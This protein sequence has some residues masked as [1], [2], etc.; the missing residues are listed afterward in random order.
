MFIMAFGVGAAILAVWADI[1]FEKVRPANLYAAMI[2]VGVAMLLAKFLV[3]LGLHL[4]GSLTTALTGVFLVG[5][6]ACVYCLLAC[7]WIMR[8]V[9]D[10]LGNARQ[11][12]GTGA[13]A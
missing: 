6:P 11:G 5:L 13:D 8:Q 3:P 4:V 2:H 12:P 7:F 1:R 9:G 10:Q